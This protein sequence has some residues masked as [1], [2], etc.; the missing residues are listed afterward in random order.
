M[1][2]VIH[3]CGTC[4]FGTLAARIATA[5]QQDLK[6]PCELRPAFWGTFRIESEGREIYNRWRT[7]GWLGRLGFGRNP[8]PAEIVALLQG[9]AAQCP[10]HESALHANVPDF[11]KS[12]S[13][14][15]GV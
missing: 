6:I 14:E 10:E 11:Q 7:N 4:G 1:S 15:P 9:I 5:V 8:Q 12:V 3:Y 2:V 13:G